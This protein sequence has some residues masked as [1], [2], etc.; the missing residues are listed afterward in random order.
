MLSPLA[1][2][3]PRR[4]DSIN[5]RA[6][7]WGLL[8]HTTGSGITAK[9][10]KTK[11]TPV[12]VALEWYRRSQ[13]GAN[14]YPWGGPGYVLGHFGELFQIADD[15]VWTNHAGG[16]HRQ[17]YL[18]G[19]WVGRCSAEVVERWRAQWP[20]VKSPQHLYPSESPNA[21]YVGVEMIPCASGYGN[22]MR[23]GLRFSREQHDQVVELARD[24]A[25]R[26]GWPAGWAR[27]PRLLGHE[28]V[29]PLPFD[30]KSKKPSY[31]RSDARGGIDPGWTR[32]DPYFDFE[33]VRAALER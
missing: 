24:L 27:T 31:G 16:P 19:E 9:A 22:P 33:Y 32:A 11:R 17:L 26:H 14:G 8:V 6:H 29:Q 1:I 7:V 10:K 5:R 3:R 2:Q 25:A 12:D 23:R 28:D 20:G 30:P 13:D 15:D 4:T 18:S 21:D